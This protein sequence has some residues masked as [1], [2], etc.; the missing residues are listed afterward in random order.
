[1]ILFNICLLILN[2]SGHMELSPERLGVQSWVAMLIERGLSA[3]CLHQLTD[4][5]LECS[6]P[7]L[8]LESTSSI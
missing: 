2:F 6:Y 5:L 7:L 1:M 3:V 8:L 4:L